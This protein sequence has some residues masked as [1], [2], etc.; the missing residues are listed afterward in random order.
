MKLKINIRYFISITKILVINKTLLNDIDLDK[1]QLNYS[2]NFK[3]FIHVVKNIF[4]LLTYLL[5]R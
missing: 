5:W 2:P 1:T 4:I 3:L